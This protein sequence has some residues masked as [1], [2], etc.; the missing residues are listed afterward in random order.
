MWVGFG[1]YLF[2]VLSYLRSMI[3]V[4]KCFYASVLLLY[5]FLLIVGKWD[6]SFSFLTFLSLLF[7]L[8]VCVFLLIGCCVTLPYFTFCTLC[9]MFGLHFSVL[10]ARMFRS[11]FVDRMA[12]LVVFFLFFR[13]VVG[14][15]IV[16][17]FLTIFIAY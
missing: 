2:F 17:V 4:W 3:L 10:T 16:H 1:Y 6:V 5:C 12:V 14:Y 15:S 8:Y 13:F 11:Y 9:A 7:F